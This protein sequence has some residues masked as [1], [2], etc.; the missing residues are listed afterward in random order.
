M[1][2]IAPKHGALNRLNTINAYADAAVKNPNMPSLAN[3]WLPSSTSSAN[4]PITA[5]EDI[6]CSLATSP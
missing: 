1:A 6:T 4:P 5:I 2:P 3:I